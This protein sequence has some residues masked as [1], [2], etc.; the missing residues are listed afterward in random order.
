MNKKAVGPIGAI[1][2][3][4]FF[5]IV[6]FVW[7]G[8]WVNEAGQIAISNGASGLETFFYTYLNFFIFIAQILGI[9]AFIYFGGSE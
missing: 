9:M 6:W 3:L 2:L 1:F 4:I 5:N 7:L 8:G